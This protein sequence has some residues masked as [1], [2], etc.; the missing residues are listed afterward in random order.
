MM[1]MGLKYQIEALQVGSRSRSL[2]VI[3]ERA[4]L[5]EN[6]L[7]LRKCYFAYNVASAECY[8]SYGAA[9]LMNNKGN[10]QSGCLLLLIMGAFRL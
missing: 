6:N 8:I 3:L 5:N 1:M 2:L 4:T 10:A 7:K 9:A